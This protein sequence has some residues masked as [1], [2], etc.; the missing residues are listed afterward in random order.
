VVDANGNVLTSSN[1]TGG[2]AAW[3]TTLVDN[4]SPDISTRGGLDD[5][6]C[7]SIGLCVV[8]D[9]NGNVVTSTNPLGGATAWTLTNVDGGNELSGVS[10]P[11]VSLCVAVDADGNGNAVTST[12]PTGDAS[13]WS[14]AHVDGSNVLNGVSCPSSTLC[15]AVDGIGDVIIGTAVLTTCSKSRGQYRGLSEP[16]S[17]L[18]ELVTRFGCS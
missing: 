17:K 15:V 14:V 2:A 1:P 13:A 7:A 4:P 5:V 8:V 10:C 18:Q 12:N 11:N 3:T 6:S 9:V 16:D